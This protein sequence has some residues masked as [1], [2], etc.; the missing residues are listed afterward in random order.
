MPQSGNVPVKNF[1]LPGGGGVTW[2]T[3][4]SY[5][6]KLDIVWINPPPAKKCSTLTLSISH[7]VRVEKNF[8][9]TGGG[10]TR[11]TCPSYPNSDNLSELPL[12]RTMSELPLTQT[13][14]EL[15]LTW[16]ISKFK[17]FFTIAGG[18][19][20][21]RDNFLSALP[22]TGHAETDTGANQYQRATAADKDSVHLKLILIL[23]MELLYTYCRLTL[24]VGALIW[25]AL[26]LVLFQAIP[27]RATLLKS[28]KNRVQSRSTHI[29]THTQSCWNL[30][31]TK[32]VQ[33]FVV[34]FLL[35]HYMET[36]FFNE[37]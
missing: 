20:Y 30:F 23:A 22:R 3:C 36:L 29:H 4:L 16:T 35:W 15:P 8:A 24:P 26:I 25:V 9:S 19:G 31:V 7:N 32:S 11:T 6:N 5:P 34:R 14:S 27:N 13:M 18:E 10:V 37:I 28:P 1:L 12:T 17:Q 33:F 21:L 2:T